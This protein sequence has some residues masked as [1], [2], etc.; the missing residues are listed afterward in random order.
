MKAMEFSAVIRKFGVNPYV[1]V[2][3]TVSDFFGHQGYIAV[4]GFLNG[5]PIRSTLVPSK[6]GE[7]R[8]YINGE[9]RKK[10]RVSV[11]DEINLTLE[12]D[13]QPRF[14]PMPQKLKE[15]LEMTPNAKVAWKSLS[16][17]KKK[18]ILRYLNWLK[19]PSAMERNTAKVIAYLLK[20]KET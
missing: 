14:Y 13:A 6:T 7:Y 20:G 8:L 12:L 3:K 9:M 5:F 2:P 11:G 18:E 4:K 10:A 16:S 19:T 15:A 17:S 1:N